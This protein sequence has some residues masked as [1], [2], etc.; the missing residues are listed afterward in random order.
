VTPN[1]FA[2]DESVFAAGIEAKDLA[3]LSSL[4]EIAKKIMDA[5]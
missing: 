5:K 1:R 3:R 4:A 2:A